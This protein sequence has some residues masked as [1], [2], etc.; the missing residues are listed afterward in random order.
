M[1]EKCASSAKGSLIKGGPTLLFLTLAQADFIY[2]AVPYHCFAPPPQKDSAD[3]DHQHSRFEI[4]DSNSEF[5]VPDLTQ[6]PTLSGFS[7]DPCY[8]DLWSS[9]SLLLTSRHSKDPSFVVQVSHRL[10]AL[11]FLAPLL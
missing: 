4:R 1:W 7:R 11:P 10:F 2:R 8:I 3:V 9:F 5:R 6:N